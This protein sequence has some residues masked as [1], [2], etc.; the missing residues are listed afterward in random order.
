MST[1]HD[2]KKFETLSLGICHLK[3]TGLSESKFLF[4][5]SKRFLQIIKI[6]ILDGN[7][8]NIY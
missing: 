6:L 8:E 2:L 1:L 5:K 7:N 3:S 4:L